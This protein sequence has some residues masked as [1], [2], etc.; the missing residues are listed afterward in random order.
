MGGVG[1]GEGGTEGETAR[2]SPFAFLH[3]PPDPFLPP[4]HSHPP[5]SHARNHCANT[6]EGHIRRQLLCAVLS[7]LARGGGDEPEQRAA[8]LPASAQAGLACAREGI[9]GD[10]TGGEPSA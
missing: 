8:P 3:P 4:T 9:G 7:L 10:E 5:D 2:E 6:L 1:G